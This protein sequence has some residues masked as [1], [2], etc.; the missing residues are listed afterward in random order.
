MPNEMLKNS[1][2]GI[3]S[4]RCGKGQA[5]AALH[6]SMAYAIDSCR[7]ILARAGSAEYISAS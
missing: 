2:P 1:V 7:G 3:F 6:E 5:R 4:A